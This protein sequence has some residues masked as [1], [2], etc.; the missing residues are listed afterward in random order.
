MAEP[1]TDDGNVIRGALTETVSAMSALNMYPEPIPG[2]VGYLS[3]TDAWA[4]HAMEHLKAVA[5]LIS[6]ADNERE[7]LKA[8]LSHGK[9]EDAL[10]LL[11]G[12]DY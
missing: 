8:F 10:K 1:R 4:K 2:V 5:V 9:I 6:Q 12:D 11:Y 7:Q 3:D